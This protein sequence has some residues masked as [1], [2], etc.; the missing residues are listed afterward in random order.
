MSAT[1]P[2]LTRE[3]VERII[4]EAREQGARPDLSGLDL[5]N[6]DLSNLDLSCLNL[7]K[8]NLSRSNLSLSNMS[9]CDLSD[10]DLSWSNMSGTVLC[11][12]R[13]RGSNLRWV[14][15]NGADLRWINWDGLLVEGL[16]PHYRR[17]LVPEPEGWWVLIGCWE[18]TVE[19]LRDLIAKDEGWPEARGSEI[20]QRRPL[21][22]VFADLCDAYAAMKPGVIE[23]LAERWGVIA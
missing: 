17:L 4:A 19:E 10:A 2:K 7:S 1:E 3:D 20:L 6:L 22:S 9:E 23:A 21:L 13:L 5:S 15:L 12:S 18:G 8:S 16:H 11:G 14:D